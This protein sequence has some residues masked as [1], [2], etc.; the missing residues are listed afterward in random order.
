VHVCLLEWTAPS[1]S[2]GNAGLAEYADQA[3]G[4]AVAT[5]SRE[6]GE[7]PL[8]LIGHS[9]GGTLAAI[10]GALHPQRVGGLVLLSAPLCF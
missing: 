4:E 7:A 2:N 6:T 9:L 1:R 8:F 10:S 5:V 3:I